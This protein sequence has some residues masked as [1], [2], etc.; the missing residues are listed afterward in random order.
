[1]SKF[2]S[3]EYQ[4]P[5]PSITNPNYTTPTET[6]EIK[7]VDS[8]LEL[9]LRKFADKTNE[10]NNAIICKIDIA[11]IPELA[12][13]QQLIEASE[14]T[15]ES[16]AIKVLKVYQPGAGKR[17]YEMQQKAYNLVQDAADKTGLAL[18]PRPIL[19]YD[20][21]I[22]PDTLQRLNAMG[23]TDVDS[24]VEILLMDYIEG[25]DIATMLLREA[26]KRNPQMTEI[27]DTANTMSFKELYEEISRFLFPTSKSLPKWNT[28][29]AQADIENAQT[30]YKFLKSKGYVLPP[31]ILDQIE[32]TMT[33]FHKNSLCFRDGHYRNFMIQDIKINGVSEPQVF[34]I[35]Y[36]LATTFEGEY[37]DEI[38]FDPARH[39]IKYPDDF[40]IIRTLRKLSESPEDEKQQESQKHT[41]EL[42]RITKKLKG[43]LEWQNIWQKLEEMKST[44]TID[45]ENLLAPIWNKQSLPT[46]PAK[47]IAAILIEMINQEQISQEQ[48]KDYLQSK[49]TSPN[50]FGEEATRNYLRI[51]LRII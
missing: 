17:E 28:E 11:H 35:D 45:L 41:E 26:I 19:F 18:V 38:Y 39:D 49:I 25:D 23:I 14:S 31:A 21:K 27:H 34:V 36:G 22:S 30:L 8:Q 48:G 43:T 47:F 7:K 6:T 15:S 40:N 10:G 1:M 13:L 4:Q 24:H 29:Q 20:L 2:P 50:I 51:I 32:K 12:D 3:G 16:Q 44:D 33:L 5:D 42:S 37:S 46:S 9:A